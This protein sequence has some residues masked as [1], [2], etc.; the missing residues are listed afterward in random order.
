LRRLRKALVVLTT[1]MRGAS[2]EAAG[3]TLLGE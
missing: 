3:E 1:V 2:R